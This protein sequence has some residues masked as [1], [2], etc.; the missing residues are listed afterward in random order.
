MIHF[1]SFYQTAEDGF[2]VFDDMKNAGAFTKHTYNLKRDEL[3]NLIKELDLDSYPKF[4]HSKTDCFPCKK[5]DNPEYVSLCVV[6]ELP[7]PTFYHERKALEIG[8]QYLP[9]D[10]SIY[11]LEAKEGRFLPDD[12]LVTN[13]CSNKKWP[14]GYSR[15]VAISTKRELAIFWLEMW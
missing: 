1:T 13:R 5:N 9:D 8:D 3:T 15:G 14:H 7:I 11:V 12:A 4:V 6:S 2:P 10:F